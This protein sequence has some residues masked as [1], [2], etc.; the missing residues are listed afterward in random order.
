MSEKRIIESTARRA[1]EVQ[2]IYLHHKEEDLPN[3]YIYRKYIKPLFHI[4]ERTF[5]RYLGRNVKKELRQLEN[6]TNDN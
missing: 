1:L 5:Y 2:E 6:A 4:S 3:R